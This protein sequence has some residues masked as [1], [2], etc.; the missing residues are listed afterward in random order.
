MKP[1]GMASL[2]VAVLICLAGIPNLSGQQAQSSGAVDLSKDSLEDLMNITVTSVSKRQQK[3]SQ[4]AAAV[5][6]ISADDIRRSGA[7]NIPDILRMAPG[8][9]V[10]QIDANTWA[11]SIRGFNSRFAN[12]VLVLIDGRSVYSPV[13]SGVNWD[14]LEMPLDNIDRIEVIRGPGASVWGANAVNGVISII[15][16]SSKDT[17]GGRMTAVAGSQVRTDD[18]V[19]YGGSAGQNATYRVFGDYFNIG[20]SAATAGGPANDRWQR[21][22]AGFRSDWDNSNGDTLM[23]QGSLFANQENQTSRSGFGAATPFDV[24]FPQAQDA[25]GGDLLA[26]WNHTFSGGSQTQV[27]TYYDTY[28]QTESGIPVKVTTLDIDLQ[29]HVAVGDRQQIV[30]GGGYRSDT[31]GAPPGF[32]VTFTPPFRTAALSNVFF[33][34][35][36][37]LTSALWFTVGAKLEHN[38]YTGFE[39]EPSARLIWAPPASRYSIWASASKAIRQPGRADNESQSTL[40]TIP[41]GGGSTELFRVVGNPAVVVEELRDYEIGYRSDI[42]KTLSFDLAT[43]LSFYHHLETIVPQTPIFLPGPPLVVEIPLLYENTAHAETYGGE[44]YLT[45]KPASRWRISPGY[46]YLHASLRLDPSSSQGQATT[47]VS[48]DFPGNTVQ[49]RSLFNLSRNMEFDQSIYYTAR[50]PGG[51]I[52][53]HARLDLRLARRIGESM[54]ISLVGQNL[55]RPRTLEYGDSSGVLGTDAVRSVYAKIAWRF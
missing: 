3:L 17:K 32:A 36:I 45:W 15:T 37:R 13:F 35:E 19:Q 47:L 44:M 49:I 12:K 24:L 41:L 48:T 23:L 9:D 55:L 22:Q 14:Q 30:W 31:S 28:R 18:E 1:S 33:Q 54:E 39:I 20:N 51:S 27:Q 16:K 42:T 7:T 34:D 38:V 8:V 29:H 4:T 21:M 43:F 25:A 6:V 11:I 50:L 40:Q 52:P 10:E 2:V 26:R 46:S 53:G 5:F